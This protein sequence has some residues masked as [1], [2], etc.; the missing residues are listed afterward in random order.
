MLQ[1]ISEIIIAGLLSAWICRLAGI[2]D[3]IGFLIT[4]I[5]F[6]PG[7]LGL[8]DPVL[9]SLSGELRLAAL[10]V[11]LLRAG[12]AL[13]KNTLK[14]SGKAILLLTFIPPLAET[15]T[16]TWIASS[17]T[18]L[19]IYES[20]L[21][22]LILSAVSPAAIVPAMLRFRE[23]GL[24]SAK[25]IPE[26]VLS[27]SSLNNVFVLM[28]FTLIIG[29]GTDPNRFDAVS[30]A[31]IPFAVLSG[32][33]IGFISARSLILVFD[34][35]NTRAT[36]KVL[37]ILALSVLFVR[38]ESDFGHIVPFS[39]LIA[40]VSM[41]IVFLNI[42]E[43]Y[44][45]ELSQKLLKIWIPA[46]MILFTLVG[47]DVD[48]VIALESGLSG[49][50]I[51]FGGLFVRS[52]INLLLMYGKSL[53]NKEKWFITIAGT[54]KATVQAAVG[55]MPLMWLT[56]NGQNTHPG[57]QILAISVLSIVLTAPA[58]AIAIEWLGKRWLKT[59]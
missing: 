44:A 30:L 47:A 9:L 31:Q 3:L 43:K 26:L 5:L 49:V 46:E 36:R 11:I 18:S 29:F 19:S 50:A 15:A 24:G 35:F 16:I 25:G 57:E 54:P 2:P 1:S 52:A 58:G 21:L 8:I 32:F 51:I 7:I 55:A 38:A 12:L 53:S 56:A 34:R 10:L 23:Q 28:L 37:L 17:L 4:G 40:T 27:I 59:E 6:G 41:G 33:L 48:P 42:R 22:G 39:A 13:H 20:L 14:R 45:S